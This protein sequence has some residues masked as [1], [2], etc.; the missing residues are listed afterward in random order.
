MAN[1][2][3][4]SGRGSFSGVSQFLRFLLLNLRPTIYQ[5]DSKD[6]AGM[7]GVRKSFQI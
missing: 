7:I 3:T 4:R 2:N 1:I 5:K 6:M